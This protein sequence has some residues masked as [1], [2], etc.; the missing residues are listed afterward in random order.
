MLLSAE[1]YLGVTRRSRRSPSVDSAR[2][3]HPTYCRPQRRRDLQSMTTRLLR[4]TSR[5]VLG[6][7]VA[8]LLIGCED[9][10]LPVP[11]PNPPLPT[12]CEATVVVM[13]KNTETPEFSWTPNCR[14]A[15]IIVEV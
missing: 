14:V 7:G 8:L 12:I 11:G 13:V 5:L 6:V 4:D 10:S 15:K 1:M 3:R 2:L 9:S